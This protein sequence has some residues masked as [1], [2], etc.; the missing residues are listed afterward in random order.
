MDKKH[1]LL[2]TILIYTFFASATN[3]NATLGT[4]QNALAGN[5]LFVSNVWAAHNNVSLL[6]NVTDF[7][8]GVFYQNRFMLKQLGLKAFALTLPVKNASFGLSYNTFGYSL[9]QENQLK[10]AYGMKLSEKVT[11]GVG[12]SWLNNQI[13]TEYAQKYN[14]ILPEMAVTFKVTDHLTVA[15]TVF[16]PMMQKIKSSRYDERIPTIFKLGANYKF[17]DKVILHTQID[18]D[19]DFD[20]SVKAGVEYI[21]SEKINLNIGV[22][23]SP[24][25]AAFGVGY[26]LNNWMLNFGASVHQQ[27]GVSPS[28]G[29]IYRKK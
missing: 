24:T 3:D 21:I 29:I 18:K 5:D 28:V 7:Q 13:N 25:I 23:T 2:F 11:A 6:G 12:L 20:A 9:F 14:F 15:T 1:F 17:S 16:N 19:L 4:Q 10:I 26:N 27:L 22:A 8:G